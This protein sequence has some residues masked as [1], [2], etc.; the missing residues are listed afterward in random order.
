MKA[1]ISTKY[2]AIV[3][4]LSVCLSKTVLGDEAEDI[5]LKYNAD[6]YP[7]WILNSSLK[8]NLS[9]DHS[10]LYRADAKSYI[11]TN[12]PH[13]GR[14]LLYRVIADTKNTISDWRLLTKAGLQATIRHTWK[15]VATEAAYVY[16]NIANSD[17]EKSE[18]LF[19]MGDALAKLN[20]SSKA[21]IIWEKALT[22]EN[23]PERA[24][25]L[26]NYKITLGK[27][28]QKINKIK[29][30]KLRA[31]EPGN[32]PDQVSLCTRFDSYRPNI[33][34]RTLNYK[35]FFSI[36][37][38]HNFKTR[39]EY[40]SICLD[41]LQPATA[42]QVTIKQSMP[43]SD[44]YKLDK[45]YTLNSTTLDYKPDFKFKESAYVLAKK[46]ENSVPITSINTTELELKL[47]HINDRNLLPSINKFALRKK[48]NIK[49]QQDY[50]NKNGSLIWSKLFKLNSLEKNKKSL[51]AIPLDKIKHKPG[52]Y[53]LTAEK[54][55][56]ESYQYNELET[57]WLVISDIGLFT[58]DAADYLHVFTHA[59]SDAKIQPNM[60]ISLIS[61]ANEVLATN[62]TDADGYAK[63]PAAMLKGKG[64]KSPKLL[65]AHSKDGD[66]GLLDI[67]R[68]EHDFSDRGVSGRKSPGSVDVFLYSNRDLFKPGETINIHGLIKDESAKTIANLQ[69][70]LK[71]INPEQKEIENISL[72]A[73]E[74]GY[75]HWQTTIGQNAKT[76]SW[77]IEVYAGAEQA[78]GEYHFFL[79]D[80]VP[81]KIKAGISTQAKSI[82]PG[83]AFDLKLAAKFLH[84]SPLAG[85]DATLNIVVKK[86]SKPFTDYPEFLFGNFKDEWRSDI[87]Q[88]SDF[89][90]IT[91]E[92]GEVNVLVKDLTEH[93]KTS[94]PLSADI[95]IAVNEPGGRPFNAKL[96]LFYQNQDAYIGLKPAFNDDV[97][98]EGDQAVFQL[99]YLKNNNQA[100]SA[101]LSYTLTKEIE[102]GHWIQNNDKWQYQSSYY[103]ESKITT[104]IIEVSAD[105]S[106]PL[107]FDKLTWGTYRLDVKTGDNT[108][109]S[110][111]FSSG[112][113]ELAGRTIADKLEVSS[114]KTDYKPGEKIRLNISPKNDGPLLISVVN[115]NLIYKKTLNAKAGKNVELTLQA[116]DNWGTGA[117]IIATSFHQNKAYQQPNRSIGLVYVKILANNTKIPL[118][119]SHAPKIEA[120][121]KLELEL[122]AQAKQESYVTVAVVDEGILNLTGYK[123]PDPLSWY[124]GQ[125]GLAVK[126]RDIYGNLIKP[127]GVSGEFRTGGDEYELEDNIAPASQNLRQV[128]A[129]FSEKIKFDS[130]GKAIISFDIPQYQGALKIMAV[131][132]NKDAVGAASSSVIVKDKISLEYYMPRFLATED[133][134]ETLL[135]VNFDSTTTEGDYQLKISTNDILNSGEPEHTISISDQANSRN[136]QKKLKLSALKAGTGKITA[137]IYQQNKLLSQRN[138]NLAVRDKYAK[139]SMFYSGTINP[140]E[141]LLSRELVSDKQYHD[142]ENIR[143]K[144]S[145]A[146]ALG[147]KTM[148]TSLVDYPHSCGEQTTSRAFPFLFTEKTPDSKIIIDNAISRL[149]SYQNSDGGFGLWQGNSSELWISAFIMDFLINAEKN[150][151]E[152]NHK[153]LSQGIKYLEDNLDRWSDSKSV[154]EANA[155]ALYSLSLSGRNLISDV[156]YHIQNKRSEIKSPLA[157]AQL[158]AVSARIGNQAQAIHTFNLA[159]TALNQTT[160]YYHNYGGYLRDMAAIILLAKQ[161]NIKLSW[162]KNYLELARLISKRSYFSTQEMS[163]I[164]RLADAASNPSSQLELNIN[165]QDQKLAS[166]DENYLK[167]KDIP[168]IKNRSQSELWYEMNLKYAPNLEELKAEKN[169]GFS[170]KRSFYNTD[171]TL[172]DLDK[173]KPNERLIV[174]IDGT[175][176]QLSIAEPLVVDVIAAGFEIENPAFSNVDLTTSVKWLDD[177]TPT[178]FTS[179]R[180]DRFIAAITVPKASEDRNF[181]LA[182]VV[183]AVTK[184]QYHLSATSIEDMYQPWLRAIDHLSLGKVLNISDNLS[185]KTKDNNAQ[186]KS[187]AQ[188]GINELSQFDYEMVNTAGLLKNQ[189]DNFS[190]VQL[191]TLRNAI[192]AKAGLDFSK[193][194]PLLHKTFSQFSWYKPVSQKSAQIYNNLELQ[195]Q[196]N[197]QTLLATEK[198][199]LGG[200]S[201]NDYYRIKIRV[202]KQNEIMNYTENQRQILR[203]SLFAR[204]GLSFSHKPKL[205]KIFK[206]MPWYHP[207]DISAA[208]IYDEV[209]SP[210]EK[211]NVQ[212]LLPFKPPG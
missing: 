192:F 38:A 151:F 10:K 114:D 142:A 40:G 172:A 65:L 96:K 115:Q 126:I 94:H 211:N 158:A 121:S 110:Y 78:V 112:N 186:T 135:T 171:G 156:N 202:L 85:A 43:I 74:S 173:I 61:K 51:T 196:E 1:N 18:F 185:A 113:T 98:D 190:V 90:F 146:P 95:S 81:P 73:D 197:I 32:T 199:R 36:Q 131:A 195:K 46:G 178:R 111:R 109:T 198:D 152:I 127:Q 201:L 208:T 116:D 76:G 22:F 138:W 119:I 75:I 83:D 92:N 102:N 5:L 206:Q 29:I 15:L 86:D 132:W 182:Y 48:I 34:N 205:D 19:I 175:I 49:D 16:R 128:V 133:T 25:A 145:N 103:D 56:A 57:Q 147:D 176:D 20:Q 7:T 31:L 69:V 141:A 100:A 66:F 50:I 72:K 160:D 106:N 79:E 169:T 70:N 149:L 99:V 187:L 183:R 12:R 105:K 89:E 189:L 68:P 6:H 64:G 181:K 28:P 41:N 164:L 129:L 180:D 210:F 9:P 170:I 118:Q 91:D 188:R 62:K 107:K 52:L 124:S 33:E 165:N 177:L 203:N 204:H 212:L 161:A 179:Y 54:P 167:F 26:Q 88:L 159:K 23:N 30:A 191:N 117:Y 193:S 2:C 130:N 84:G 80:F 4:L 59:L 27:K 97:I 134:A 143:L 53:L 35:K 174:V 63:I 125:L 123:S 39:V 166:F 42:Y 58:M 47:I 11:Q 207:T 136:Y 104:G 37:P 150:H 67:S 168:L 3:L 122:T 93:Y 140:N 60:K 139:R 55:N 8:E 21:I 108:H 13:K 155:Y 184:G 209:M 101:R 44:T 87:V 82:I 45:T 163:W 24:L 200:L 154:Q 157:W 148:R 77:S 17:H 153:A 137:G 162:D 120:D 144:I 71:L 14:T 194:Q